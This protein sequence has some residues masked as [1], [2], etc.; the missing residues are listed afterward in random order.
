MEQPEEEFQ[1]YQESSDG[2]DLLE[3]SELLDAVLKETLNN[4]S[5][6]A[7]ELIFDVARAS[8]YENTTDIRAVEEV[9]REIVTRRLGMRKLSPRVI[10]VVAQTLID[11]PEVAVKLERLWQEGRSRG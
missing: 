8:R 9:V 11:E 5:H 10:R 3:D 6:D 2:E 7:L 4:S 1:Q